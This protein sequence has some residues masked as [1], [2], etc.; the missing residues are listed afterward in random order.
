MK[1]P[2][3]KTETENIKVIDALNKNKDTKA[4]KNSVLFYV[5]TIITALLVVVL[6]IGGAFFFAIKN[7]VNGMA[8]TMGDS[9]ANV[10]VLK[11][12]LPAKPEPD[13]E[14]NMT[15]EQVRQKFTQIKGEKELLEKQLSDVTAQ[16]DTLNK[17]IAAKE[18]DSSLLLQQKDTLEK[19][20]LQL[21]ADNA[22]LKK[23]LD[24]ISAT[25]AKGDTTEFKSYFEKINTAIAADI[26][27]E[28][29]AEEKIS[30]DVKKYC[31]IYE[32]MDAA[33]VSTI[34]E[35]MGNSKMDLI[36]EIMK[37]LKKD[38]TAEI[39]TEMTPEFAAKVSEQLAKEYNVGAVA[40]NTTA[41][42]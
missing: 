5:L 14:K 42:K 38:T 33:A 2:Q 25:I 3:T 39:L 7:N 34:L 35:Q 16:L 12:A 13:D 41:T 40:K 29:L 8:D 31:S 37:N 19:E 26:Y 27:S 23:D 21:A 10:P 32:E 30:D 18:T 20:K 6:I 17:Q 4:E 24:G 22:S 9:V 11:W 15:E 1:M 36:I 28:I